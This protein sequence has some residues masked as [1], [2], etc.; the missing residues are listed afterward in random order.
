MKMREVDIYWGDAGVH[1]QMGTRL[2]RLRDLD[3][4]GDNVG[5]ANCSGLVYEN[6]KCATVED[7]LFVFFGIVNSGHDIEDVH[8]QFMK[9]DEYRDW[10]GQDRNLS[11]GAARRKP[12]KF[13]ARPARAKG[14]AGT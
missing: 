9:I 6:W 12:I 5:T 2:A 8:R 14:V 11:A 7:L 4:L 10:Y 1:V 13:G 3:R